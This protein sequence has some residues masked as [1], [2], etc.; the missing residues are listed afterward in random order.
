MGLSFGTL[1]GLPKIHKP[2]P[3]PFRSILA[4][5]NL[6]N[7]K[8]AKYLVP[9][10]SNLTTNQYSVK[11][12]YEFTDIITQINSKHYLVSYDIESLF[13]NIPIDETI[14]IILNHLFPASDSMYAICR[15]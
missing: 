7:F 11:N 5:Y 12:S 2:K 13:T 15:C 1:Y 6:P 10:L 4:A 3:V 9:L 14:N 8:L